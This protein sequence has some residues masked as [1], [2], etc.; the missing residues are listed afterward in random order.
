MV[1]LNSSP[2]C[3]LPFRLYCVP[4]LNP[5][6]TDDSDWSKSSQNSD[7]P[8]TV[9]FSSLVSLSTKKDSSSTSGDHSGD[10]VITPQDNLESVLK[11]LSLS[12]HLKL[13]KVSFRQFCADV[14]NLLSPYENILYP[15]LYQM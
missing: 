15:L 14:E 13:F 12:E 11:K 9:A 7:W 1:A 10:M 2:A 4:L 5:L 3:F 6:G 8:S